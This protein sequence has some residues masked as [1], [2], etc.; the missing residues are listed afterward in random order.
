MMIEVP[1]SLL[2]RV[3]FWMHLGTGLTA[4]LLILVMSVTGVLLTYEH[5]IIE[6]AARHNR[7]DL[8]PDAQRLTADELAA[9]ARTNLPP[10]ARLTL[11][12][13]ARPTEPV[14]IG[15]GRETALLLHPTS[16]AVIADA[17]A[18]WRRAFSAIE[19][20]HRWLGGEP[21]STGAHLMDA[22]NL[23]FLF[24]AISGTYLWLPA[25][26]RWRTV[27]GLLLTQRRYVNSRVRDFNWHHV[28]SAWMLVPLLLISAS[29]VVI[30]YGWASNLVY[31]AFGESA[32][33]RPGPGGGGPGAG[34]GTGGQA[35]AVSA[36]SARAPAQA[37][38]T[39]ASEGIPGWQRLT[40]PLEFAAERVSIT[41]EVPST[42]VRPQRRSI[43][44]SSADASVLQPAA[45]GPP[46]SAGQRAR[47]WLRFVH[48]GEQYGLIGQTLAGLAS[49]AT[50]LLIY[51]GV[52]LA[53]RRLFGQSK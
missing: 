35:S 14:A 46:P 44:L 36:T 16:G 23:M 22:A 32:P 42:D 26:W 33:Q 7:V 1:G 6:A 12:V 38:L 51:T 20:W 49:L 37:L 19:R 48:T 17:A 4:G 39:A 13:D 15:V 2:R 3:V 11:I 53:W 34:T 24:L 5:Q 52:A 9:I 18:P 28:A 8:A 10:D 25:V 50:C 21:R 47:V 40:L 31:A 29:G 43:V 41:A 45:A 30:S 27:R